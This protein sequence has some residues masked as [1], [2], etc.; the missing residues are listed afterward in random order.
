M[1]ALIFVLIL[2]IAFSALP[3]IIFHGVNDECNSMMKSIARQVS[4]S[5]DAHAECMEIGDGTI[6]SDLFS[7][8]VQGWYACRKIMNSKVFADGFNLIGFSQGGIIA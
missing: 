3:T 6:T 5:T 8:P 7:V 2:S 4:E 1:R